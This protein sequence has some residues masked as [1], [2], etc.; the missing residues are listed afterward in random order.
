MIKATW[1]ERVY[2]TLQFSG[3]SPSLWEF[4]A[5]TQGSDLE[6]AAYWLVHPAFL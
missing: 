4:T 6:M 5:G 2:L 1:E 3:H